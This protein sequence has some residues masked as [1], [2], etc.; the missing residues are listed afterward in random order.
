M[1]RHLAS[2]MSYGRKVSDLFVKQVQGIN[3]LPFAVTADHSCAKLA[4]IGITL[5]ASALCIF[6]MI[7]AWELF[8]ANLTL[9]KIE[10]YDDEIFRTLLHNL[11]AHR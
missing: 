6:G 2:A 10:V 3:G 1:D 9:T 7:Q 8:A 11:V 4:W 5:T